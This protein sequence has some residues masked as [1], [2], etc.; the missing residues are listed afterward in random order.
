MSVE[1]RGRVCWVR[2]LWGGRKGLMGEPR[3]EE[4]VVAVDVVW[5]RIGAEC[6]RVGLWA[7]GA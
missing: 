1:R 5:G 3:V 4:L 2:V 6:R 7:G